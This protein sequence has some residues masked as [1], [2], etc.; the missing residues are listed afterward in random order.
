LP[1]SVPANNFRGRERV[2]RLDGEAC[3]VH[4]R[5]ATRAELARAG[6]RFSAHAHRRF[7][8]DDYRPM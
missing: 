5:A 1:G 3:F 8:G 4:A 6:R 2:L 7:A